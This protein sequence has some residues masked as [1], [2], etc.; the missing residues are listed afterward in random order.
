MVSLARLLFWCRFP[1]RRAG[2]FLLLGQKKET[3]EKAAP[4]P[5]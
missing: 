2:F 1:H 4:L 3:K 5:L